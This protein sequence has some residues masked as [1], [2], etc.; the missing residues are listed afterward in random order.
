MY[1]VASHL[2]YVA[3]REQVSHVWVSGDLKYHKPAG[4]VGVFSNIEPQELSEIVYKWQ[5]KLSEFGS[6]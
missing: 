3:G 5:T 1:D 4:N 2:V 6:S